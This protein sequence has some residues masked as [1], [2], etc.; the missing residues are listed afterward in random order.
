MEGERER[1]RKAEREKGK[2]KKKGKEGMTLT[3]FCSHCIVRLSQQVHLST[4]LQ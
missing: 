3:H 1:W 4:L 2:E